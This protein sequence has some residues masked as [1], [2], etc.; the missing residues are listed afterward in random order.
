MTP[1]L[2]KEN[3][4]AL[5]RAKLAWGFEANLG[6][7]HS[8]G[9]SKQE[10]DLKI[11]RSLTRTDLCPVVGWDVAET[12]IWRQRPDV[13][14]IEVSGLGVSFLAIPDAVRFDSPKLMLWRKL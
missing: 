6:P 11:V 4:P 12:D 10:K 7:L 14:S 13:I 1:P 5:I 2:Q 8:E 9:I 3:D